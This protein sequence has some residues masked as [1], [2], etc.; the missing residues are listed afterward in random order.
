M[1]AFEF[2]IDILFFRTGKLSRRTLN[3]SKKIFINSYE[4]IFFFKVMVIHIILC[5]KSVFAGSYS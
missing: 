3:S 1:G 4:K 2:F 5:L